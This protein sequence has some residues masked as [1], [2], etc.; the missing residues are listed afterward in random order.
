MSGCGKQFGL[1]QSPA[2]R[3]HPRYELS[4]NWEEV[5]KWLLNY[6][7]NANKNTPVASAIMTKEANAPRRLPSMSLLKHST[8]HQKT[9][10]MKTRYVPP[11]VSDTDV[12]EIAIGFRG[13]LR[14]VA[15]SFADRSSRQCQRST[16]A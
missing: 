8:S 7:R 12:R 4:Q 9:T 13:R 6:A 3:S 2:V 14:S 10:K 11:Q 16:T 15:T 1:A 5:K